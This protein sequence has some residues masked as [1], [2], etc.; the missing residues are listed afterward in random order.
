MKLVK[1]INQL[2]FLLE[3]PNLVKGEEVK[4]L[5]LKALGI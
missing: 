1:R 5:I 3:Q 4:Y 2:S